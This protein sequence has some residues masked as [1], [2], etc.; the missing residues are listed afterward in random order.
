ADDEPA[1]PGDQ[2]AFAAELLGMPPPPEIPFA[3]AQKTMTPFAL[4]F[5]SES[6]R[7]RNDRLKQVLG[8]TLRYPTYREGLRALA[9][10][11]DF[12]PA[13]TLA[14][15]S[16]QGGQGRP[17]RR[18]IPHHLSPPAPPPAPFP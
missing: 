3:E 13:G 7:V 8:V 17:R 5:Y 9:A 4:S 18:A 14:R 12:T 6:R 15:R 11:G 10:Q 16:P 2:I 1:P